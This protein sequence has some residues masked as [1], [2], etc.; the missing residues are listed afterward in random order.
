MLRVKRK[1]FS[2]IKNLINQRSF[3]EFTTHDEATSRKFKFKRG[4][5]HDAIYEQNTYRVF[6]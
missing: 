3:I 1:V 2:I 4:F 5:R 6:L